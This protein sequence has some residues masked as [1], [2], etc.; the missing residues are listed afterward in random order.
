MLAMHTSASR[1][2]SSTKAVLRRVLMAVCLVAIAGRAAAQDVV[3][4]IPVTKP[5]AVAVYEAGNKVFVADDSTGNVYTYDGTSLTL[6]NTAYVG[7]MVSRMVVH[8]G[9]GKLFVLPRSPAKVAVLDAT[10]GSFIKYLTLAYTTGYGMAV[11]ESLGKVYAITGMEGL[12]QIDVWT[13]AETTVSG[14]GGG[15][16]ALN[17]VTHQVF[18]LSGVDLD[19]VDGITLAKTT[20]TSIK[21]YG[22]AVNWTNNKVYAG[23]GCATDASG[24]PQPCIYDL[25]TGTKTILDTPR[26]QDATALFYNPVGNRVYTGAEVD[27]ISTVIEG[28][29]DDHHDIPLRG[30]TDGFGVRTGT[31]HVYLASTNFV[32]V[33]DDATQMV[34]KISVPSPGGGGFVYQDVAINQSTGRVFVINDGDNYGHL[35]VIQDT[36]KL[37]RQPIVLT[38]VGA[39]ANRLH[40]Y[41]PGAEAVADTVTPPPGPPGRAIFGPGGA[42]YYSGRNFYFYPSLIIY[43]GFGPWAQIGSVS[44]GSNQDGAAPQVSAP[45]PDG[46]R[47]YG[48]RQSF[49]DVVVIDLL[50]NTVIGTIA[51]G[52]GPYGMGFTPDGGKLYVANE[53]ANTVKVIS[54]ASDTVTATIAVGAGPYGVAVNPSGKKAY[55][56]NSGAGTVSVID[57]TSDTVTGTIT[58]GTSPRSLAFSPDGTRLY[59]TNWTSGTVSVI[60][61]GTDTVVA[62]VSGLTA[63]DG[64]DVMPD[65]SRVYVANYDYDAPSCL[66]VI[67]PADLSTTTRALP[68]NSQGT[69]GLSIANNMA[70]FAGRVTAASGGAPVS[71][72][73]VRAL[74]DGVVKGTA[75]TNAAGDYAVPN[76]L[77]GT[78][79]LDISATGFTG[80]A[81]AGQ[82][83]AS[84]RIALHH[85]ALVASGP[86]LPVASFTAL[87]N[88]CACNQNVS[89]DGTGSFHQDPTRSIV[90]WAWD[91]GD[92]GTGAGPIVAHSYGT[93]GG[94][95]AT[96]TVTDNGAPPKTA[97]ATVQV[98]VSQGNLA[99]VARPGGPYTVALGGSLTLDG[100]ASADPNAACGDA[101][102]QWAWDLT[103]DG[104]YEKTGSTSLLLAG[105]IAALGVGVHTLTLRVT[106]SFG[107]TNTAAT[108]L[109]V[110]GSAGTWSK[111]TIP[112]TDTL[113]SVHFPDV[114]NGWAV[115]YNG[116]IVHTAN[117]G[118]TWTQQTSR[119]TQRFLAVRFADATTGWAGAG[120]LVL[121]TTDGGTNW[122]DTLA[123]PSVFKF[124]NS[125]F[126]V[127]ATQAW[128]PVSSSGLPTLTRWFSRYTVQ[129]D[130][131]VREEDFNVL[132]ST[133][134]F[135]DVFFIDPDNGW[136]IGTPG[137]IVR[138][139]SASSGTPTFTFQTSGTGVSLNGVFMLDANRGWVVGNEGTILKTT[140]GGA[141]WTPLTSGT[142]TNLRDIH[143]TDLNN[144]WAVGESGLIRATTDGGATWTSQ[145]S[146]V[147]TTLWS[148]FF[149][150]P[151]FIA[152]GDAAGGANG[153]VLKLG[154]ANRPPEARAGDDQ[155]VEES[156]LVTLSGAASS[157]P[158]GDP[159]TYAWS[160][161]SGPPVTLS[162]AVTV[163]ATFTPSSPGVYVFRLDVSDG[164]GGTSS[165]TVQ[166]TVEDT[167]PP[168]VTVT[169]PNGGEKLFTGWPY[170][171]T[172]TASDNGTLSF[173]DVFFS[174]NSGGAWAPVPGCLGVSGAA[175]S[176][177]WAAPGPVTSYGRIRVVAHDAAGNTGMDASDAN[178]L[179]VAGTGTL[180]VTQPTT[181]LTWAMGAAVPVRWSHS[182]GASAYVMIELSR[183]GGASW[184]TLNPSV[185]NTGSTSGTWTWVV[186]GPATTHGRVR[187]T[188]LRGPASDT[189][190]VDFVIANQTITV[191][192]P[193]TALTWVVGASQQVKW[194]HNAGVAAT[195]LIELSRDGGATYPQTIAAAAP[196]TTATTGVYNWTVTGPPVS[197]LA[198]VRVT[199]TTNP[200]SR[201]TSNVG[202][203]IANPLVTVTQPNTAL[204]WAVGGT[205][206]IKWT[207]NLGL[208]A[209]FT[210]E[211]SRDD[212]ATYP[213]VVATSAP[214]TTST[215]G[216]YTWTVTGPASTQARARVTY[217]SVGTDASNVAFTIAT[218]FITMSAPTSSGNWG[219]GATQ[220]V[221][222]STN[223]GSTDLVNVRLSTDGGVSFPTLLATGVP[224]SAKAAAVTTPTLGAPT[225][226]AR[227][228]VELIANPALGGTNPANFKVQSPF[229]AMTNPTGPTHIWTVGVRR[230]IS[231]SQNLGSLESVRVELSLDGGATYPVVLFA[232]TPSDG[233]QAVVPQAGWVTEHG[234]VKIAWL[235]DGSITSTSAQDFP[236]R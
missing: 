104:T 227:V 85:C 89:L 29:T 5:R 76:L 60:D 21:G 7:T 71:G 222:W 188:W 218:P 186:T 70:R 219:Y 6:L 82:P 161:V 152:G 47:V 205:Q 148:V 1:A 147:T 12:R 214:A 8:E 132:E 138:I 67:N 87:P 116:T 235:R 223:L 43:A 15:W 54:T 107:A 49:D 191:T 57:T 202:F 203:T 75:T 167:T 18:T 131:S 10:N 55:I 19:I 25:N 136:A 20:I 164:H 133:A 183:D 112:T 234:R 150:N 127:S 74:Q 175:R 28:A 109:T 117:G 228:R 233:G 17:P 197:S 232:G 145:S 189:S 212:G 163:V 99:P 58:V 81:E 172:W 149:V 114:D 120:R 124:R 182:L 177:G 48:S 204:N 144:G 135:F 123:D 90:S 110:T 180:T 93:F 209:V 101:I 208:A 46:A 65:G 215:S 30:A 165:D 24:Y 68:S 16:I 27:A 98:L 196:A 194:S 146:G 26:G 94:F 153:V 231:W 100:S 91:F 151:G 170:T 118:T 171:I 63:P 64:V 157:D 53:Y 121:R 236:I 168:D 217:N 96:L 102:V 128:A 79:D 92:G 40:I 200:A 143:F 95:A 187:V 35:V 201:D 176:C 158:D 51:V 139:G 216:T 34:E 190:D 125:L 11:D 198:R 52:D 126:A 97:T 22:V 174:T 38:S 106:D 42:R 36:E 137:Q 211:I 221:T 86:L 207:H 14:A 37:T 59:V 224:A 179:V 213:E 108:T 4:T 2:S 166:V 193:N 169:S 230:T 3:G 155:T 113:R 13:L 154:S 32:A 119:T 45:S 61:P 72:A 23:Y 184:E 225:A 73:L 66:T 156:D 78:Y 62:T 162:S 210:I 122:V 50:T 88:P 192:Q 142:T 33:V 83:A 159:I 185:K 9:S 31:N 77:P 229:V 111:L 134:S 173:F 129:G 220:K 178:H 115:G 41:D 130:G 80:Q 105:D 226:L 103:S 199:L 181:A 160:Q 140:N 141:S 195:F 44:T 84:G 69:Y 39:G 56:A 206:Q